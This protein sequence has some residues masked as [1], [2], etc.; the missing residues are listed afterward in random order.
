MLSIRPAART[1]LPLI[2]Q[3]IRDL[4]EYEKLSD[5]VRF[6]EAV[7]GEKLFGARHYAEV[8]IGEVDGKAQGFA[9]FFH[10]FSTFEGL[11]GIYLED[12]FVRPEARGAGLGKALLAHLAAL[13][14]ER[15]CARLEWSV[16]DWN[17][18]AIGFYEKLGARG[19]D[20]WTVMRLDGANLDQLGAAAGSPAD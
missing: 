3:F 15:G 10:N 12:L 4:A 14:V 6:D 7:M 19:M 8:V 16:L 17:A 5:A 9:L 13:A 11:P 20:D 2:A 1:D 18:P